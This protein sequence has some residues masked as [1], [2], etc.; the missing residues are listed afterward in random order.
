VIRSRTTQA[1]AHPTGAIRAITDEPIPR[2]LKDSNERP[3]SSDNDEVETKLDLDNNPPDGLLIHTAAA[4][5]DGIRVIDV[6]E[7]ADKFNAFNEGT[8]GPIVIE[9][10]GEPPADAPTPEPEITELHNVYQP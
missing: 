3:N 10:M 7:S 9:V 1:T 6:W 2:P 5:G 4:V 8:L